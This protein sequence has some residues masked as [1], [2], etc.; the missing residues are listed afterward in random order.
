MYL[1]NGFSIFVSYSNIIIPTNIR[2]CLEIKVI[3]RHEGIAILILMMTKIA[4]EED[5]RMHHITIRVRKMNSSNRSKLVI[6]IM[7]LAINNI[8]K[9]GII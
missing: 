1:F 9:I 4:E 3:S 8:T 2:K 5:I 7:K 6:R